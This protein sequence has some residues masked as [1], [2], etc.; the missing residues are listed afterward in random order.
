M[1]AVENPADDLPEIDSGTYEKIDRWAFALQQTRYGLLL[2]CE[3]Q[4]RLLR[5]Q[6]AATVEPTTTIMAKIFSCAAPVSRGAAVALGLL[7]RG[8]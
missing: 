3:N 6:M 2:R 4:N 8:E 1:S 7:S 5:K